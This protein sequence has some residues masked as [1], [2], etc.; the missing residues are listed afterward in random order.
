MTEPLHEPERRK[1][2]KEIAK[3]IDE[4]M[5]YLEGC[6][7][8]WLRR[9]LIAMVIMGV[10]CT[11]G[12]IGFG[13]ALTSQRATDREIRA[14][15]VGAD[16]QSKTAIDTVL[17]KEKICA[18]SSTVDACRALFNRLSKAVTEEQRYRLGCAAL[19]NLYG[20]TAKA[21][22]EDNPKCGR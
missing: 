6:F 13:I 14:L 20:P 17:Q 12:L 18:D 3:T 19:K 22:R 16:N 2:Y 4:R 21:I 11:V 7:S 1:G 15:A 5:A 10:G 8:R 9:G